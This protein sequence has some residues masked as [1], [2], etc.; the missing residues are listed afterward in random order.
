MSGDGFN[1]FGTHERTRLP[2]VTRWILMKPTTSVLSTRATAGAEVD[3]D[4]NGT[5]VRCDG[6]VVVLGK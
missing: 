1:K 6:E 5:V 2:L 3:I 4:L